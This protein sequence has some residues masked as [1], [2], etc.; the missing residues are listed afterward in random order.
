MLF[1]FLLTFVPIV[2]A[3]NELYMGF[4]VYNVK[5]TS[6]EQQESLHFL[7][8]DVIDYWIKPNF[9]YDVT[10]L[11]MVPPSH[12]NWFEERL[13]ELQVEKEIA[14]EDVY[15]YLS[16]KESSAKQKVPSFTYNDDSNETDGSDDEA[17]NNLTEE[18]NVTDKDNGVNETEETNVTSEDGNGGGETKETDVTNEDDK[19]EEINAVTLTESDED[20][21]TFGF[22]YYYRYSTLHLWEKNLSTKSS[23]GFIC[24]GV[25]INRNFNIDWSRADSSSSACSHLYAGTEANSEIET[26]LIQSIIHTYKDRISMY[27]SLQN[28]GGYIS[29]PWQYE[30]AASGTFRQN[31]LLAM[32]MVAAMHD[33]YHL[34]VASV[35][36]GDR[37]SGTSSD[38]ARV[39]DVMYAF[40]IDI[41]RRGSDGV[42]VPES[43]IVDVVEDVWR[44]VAVAAD[45]LIN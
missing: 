28:G 17:E 41:V 24:P 2:I 13:E 40:N 27:I 42:I 33:E 29:Y 34:D 11:A 5:L 38:Y 37:A 25:N 21:I 30:F 15:E 16:T 18:N 1:L 31:H 4:K 10:G 20:D 8:A 23:W 45:R 39:N 43:E 14:I 36:Y 26:Q 19:T 32:E 12:F 6:Q 22:D 3:K 35:A 7:K 44:A 9:K